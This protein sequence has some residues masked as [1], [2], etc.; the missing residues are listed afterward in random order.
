[1]ESG[2]AIYRDTYRDTGKEY[3]DISRYGNA[4]DTQLY[5]PVAAWA[6][7]AVFHGRKEEKAV[8]IDL[9]SLVAAAATN[10]SGLAWT[11]P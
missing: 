7:I 10:L 9:K 8:T 2:A 11:Q 6:C 4:G 5:C 1:M 3:R